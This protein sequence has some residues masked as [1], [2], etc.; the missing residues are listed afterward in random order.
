[1]KKPLKKSPVIAFA[2][3]LYQRAAEICTAAN[4]GEDPEI[5]IKAWEGS[6][7][8]EI[9]RVIGSLE[10]V[11]IMERPEIVPDKL[12]KGGKNT[13][14]WH[15]TIESN[16]LL[17]GDGWDA[18]DLADIIQAGFH[19]WRRNHARLMMTEVIVTNSKPAAPA[20]I[21]KKSIILTMETT[22]IIKHG[23]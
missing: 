6:L 21:L 7:E 13:A 19:K 15:V 4:D 17:D 20:K 8:E 14:K 12:S 18:D 10:T 2:E 1:M 22:L 9:K 16:P 3:V 23:N 5:I 11:I